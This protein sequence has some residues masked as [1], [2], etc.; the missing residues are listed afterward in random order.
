MKSIAP[1]NSIEIPTAKKV[2]LTLTG[3]LK[4]DRIERPTV[5]GNFE[6]NL[7]IFL[8]ETLTSCWPLNTFS[9]WSLDACQAGL[10]PASRTTNI[11]IETI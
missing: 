4:L 5:A 7:C 3:F 2:K 1:N 10:N 6:V 11:A 9:G 8:D